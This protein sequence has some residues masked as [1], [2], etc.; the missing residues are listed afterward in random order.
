MLGIGLGAPLFLGGGQLSIIPWSGCRIRKER[1]IGTLG[2]QVQSQRVV[3]LESTEAPTIESWE[4][5]LTG[6][7]LDHEDFHLNLSKRWTAGDSSP[8]AR[9]SR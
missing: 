2:S 3:G 7:S 9:F 6:Q 1:E 8:T 5:L 4:I